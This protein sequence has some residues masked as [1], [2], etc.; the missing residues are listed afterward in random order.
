[1]LPILMAMSFDSTG[2][3]AH[4]LEVLSKDGKLSWKGQHGT[5]RLVR[6]AAVGATISPLLL[7]SRVHNVMSALQA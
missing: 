6:A 5:L 1:M 2:V 3:I 7:L 4:L